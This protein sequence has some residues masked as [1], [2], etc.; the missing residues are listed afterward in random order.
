MVDQIALRRRAAEEVSER[1]GGL[2]EAVVVAGDFNMPTDSAIYRACW[3]SL[4]NAFSKAGLGFG[5]TEWPTVA[6]WRFGIRIDHILTGPGWRPQRCWVG[7][8]VG[9]DHLP[10][11]A[12]IIAQ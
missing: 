1:I 8:D 2:S 6:G 7:P 5:Y 3:S 11:L 9:S 4:S 10:L 12:D